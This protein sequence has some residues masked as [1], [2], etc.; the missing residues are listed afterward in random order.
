MNLPE[1]ERVIYKCNPLIEVIC[2]LRFPPILKISHEEPVDFQDKIRLH[3][4]LFE[5]TRTQIPA[6][7]SK[8][9]QQFDL[10]LQSDIAYNF[11][12]EDQR[13]NLTLTKDFIALSTSSYER[14]EQYKQRFSIALDIF[15][16]IYKPS[17]YSRLGLRYK[18]L[19]IR[20]KL[21]FESREWSD[22]IAKRFASELHDE[23]LSSS[24]QGIAKNLTLKSE[25][26]QVNLNHGLVT[27]KESQDSNEETAYLI[28]A[29][30]FSEQKIEGNENVWNVLDQFN[31]SAGRLFRWSITEILHDALQPQ[32]IDARKD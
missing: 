28:D 12:S 18:D 31:R 11:K 7:L 26:I 19:I 14:Y 23:E 25:N 8:F 9:V 22:L 2:Q 1:F 15:D 29:D 17:F 16:R 30:F 32:P 13:W 21:G 24:I 10:P 3:Y 5:T 20:S 6:E 27:I 4:P